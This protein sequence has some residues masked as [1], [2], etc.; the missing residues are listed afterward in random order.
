MEVYIRSL[1]QILEHVDQDNGTATV[2]PLDEPNS[3]QSI[4]VTS[5][6]EH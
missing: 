2:H 1:Q 6:E 4:S 3:K 5:L